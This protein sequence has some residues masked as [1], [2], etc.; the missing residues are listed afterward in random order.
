MTVILSRISA[1]LE[2]TESTATLKYPFNLFEV[3]FLVDKIA[4]GE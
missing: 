4:D 2:A 3:T 1:L